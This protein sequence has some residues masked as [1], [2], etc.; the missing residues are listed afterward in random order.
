[1]VQVGTRELKAHLSE[2][3]R[4]AQAGERVV[5][6]SHGRPVAQLVSLEATI[7]RDKETPEEVRLR[8]A[9][10]PGVT[11][12]T[13]NHSFREVA[14]VEIEGRPLSSTVIEERR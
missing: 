12:P 3:L 1:M 8:L 6:T 5:V 11:P 10:M 7:A 9:S 2:Y 13:R 14:P 4:K